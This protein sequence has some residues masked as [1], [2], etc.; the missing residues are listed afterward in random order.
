MTYILLGLLNGV[1]IALSRILNGQLS[2]YHGPTRA[3]YVN[4]VGGFCLLSLLALIMFSPPQ[5]YFDSGVMIYAGG[6]IGALYVAINSLVIAKL[7]ST[8]AIILVISGQMLFSLLLDTPS[9]APN[10]LTM[11]IIGVSLIVLGI[12]LKELI[13]KHNFKQRQLN[14]STEYL[15]KLK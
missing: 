14:K 2:S 6:V 13:S 12:S 15:S 7:G 4:H 10:S 5:M 8:S 1:C 11:K 3:S 9:D